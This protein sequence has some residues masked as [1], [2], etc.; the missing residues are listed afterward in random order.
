MTA[1]EYDSARKVTA[2]ESN[3]LETYVLYK[4][5]D[6]NVERCNIVKALYY[7]SYVIQSLL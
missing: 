2:I 3:T 7:K 4:I 1:D 5:L 6:Y